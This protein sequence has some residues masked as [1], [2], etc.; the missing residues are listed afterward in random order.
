MRI[1]IISQY[2]VLFIHYEFHNDYFV[3]AVIPLL[4]LFFPYPIATLIQIQ[5]IDWYRASF[6]GE[7]WPTS[8]RRGSIVRKTKRTCVEP[9]VND[10][11]PRNRRSFAVLPIAKSFSQSSSLATSADFPRW[12]SRRGVWG[13]RRRRADTTV[14]A[15]RLVVFLF[16]PHLY[17]SANWVA[18]RMLARRAT[19]KSLGIGDIIGSTRQREAIT[20]CR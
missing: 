14:P 19:L 6:Y 7:Q 3:F 15:T 12:R 17:I 13:V 2:Y 1:Q 4:N 11:W 8:Q 16:I 18:R 10:T 5:I 9:R 20:S